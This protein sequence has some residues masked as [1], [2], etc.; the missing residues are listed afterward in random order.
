MQMFNNNSTQLEMQMFNNNSRSIISFLYKQNT[1][2]KATKILTK[3]RV[4][5]IRCDHIDGTWYWWQICCNLFSY[6]WCKI[7]I[8]QKKQQNWSSKYSIWTIRFDRIDR[9][10]LLMK[11]FYSFGCTIMGSKRPYKHVSIVRKWLLLRVHVTFF[12]NI[13]HLSITLTLVFQHR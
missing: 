4:R 6:L 8:L 2:V 12:W 9:M 10:W 5:L 3:Y 1:A 11:I 7:K 13:Y